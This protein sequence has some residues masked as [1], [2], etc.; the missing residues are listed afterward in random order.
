MYS[1]LPK[2]E[3]PDFT[4]AKSAKVANPG[5]SNDIFSNFSDLS[6]R[7]VTENNFL[8]SLVQSS[9]PID[10]ILTCYEWRPRGEA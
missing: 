6:Y 2:P 9:K 8:P 5:K 4:P 3:F 1:K 7:R 10:F